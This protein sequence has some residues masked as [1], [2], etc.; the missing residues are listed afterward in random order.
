M[1]NYFEHLLA[2]DGNQELASSII[3]MFEE[4]EYGLVRVKING[5]KMVNIQIMAENHKHTMSFEDCEALNEIIVDYLEKSETFYED[6]SLEISSPGIERPLT[7]EKDFNIWSDNFVKIKLKSE[8]ELPRKFK[9]KLLGYFENKVKI[10]I[11]NEK[12][13][14]GEYFLDPLSIKE[15]ILTWVAKDP[16]KPNLIS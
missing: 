9:A 6:Y 16:P 5:T 13:Y 12:D 2:P 1:E 3:S 4:L 8:N 7:R 15:I 11:E 14:N 10:Y